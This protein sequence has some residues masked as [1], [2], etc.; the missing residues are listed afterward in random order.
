MC[1]AIF[2][3]HASRQGVVHTP[4]THPVMSSAG[5][6]DSELEKAAKN[7]TRPHANPTSASS[8]RPVSRDP[9]VRNEADQEPREPRKG[10]LT[11]PAAQEFGFEFGERHGS[12]RKF[13]FHAFPRRSVE[14]W[15]GR[16]I[17]CSGDKTGHHS[18]PGGIGTEVDRFT[19]TGL[20]L[21]RRLHRTVPPGDRLPVRS[22]WIP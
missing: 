18:A 11:A 10:G 15:G 6:H 1:Q 3:G 14:E 17:Y 16:F 2:C 4:R 12:H 7:R 5:P 21:R 9:S 22:M 20:W 13:E 19:R 8:M